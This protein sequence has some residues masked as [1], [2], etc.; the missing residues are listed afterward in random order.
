MHPTTP[1]WL[2]IDRATGQLKTKGKLDFEDD[3]TDNEYEVVVRATDPDGMP[4]A[5][6]AV[7]ENSDVITVT[8]TVT[9]VNE[10]PEFVS[11]DDAIT[12]AENGDYNHHVGRMPTWRTTRR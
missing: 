5:D 12:F 7:Q 9:D 3:N 1:T 4:E 8:I 2:A 10:A 11:G 6:A